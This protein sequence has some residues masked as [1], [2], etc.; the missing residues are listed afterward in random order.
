MIRELSDAEVKKLFEAEL[1]IIVKKVECVSEED[2]R[3]L[4]DISK[5]KENNMKK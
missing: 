5:I 4:E 2:I 3:I 1:G